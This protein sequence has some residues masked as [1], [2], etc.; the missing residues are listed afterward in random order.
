MSKSTSEIR[1]TFLDF[2]HSKGHQIVASS[3]L[4]PD[5]NSTLLFTNAG[6][7]QFQNVFLGLEKRPYLRAATAQR[8][9]RAGGKHNDL[10]NVGYSEYHHTFF[11]MLGNFSFG[12]Y[13]K[14]EAI[15]FAWELLTSKNW[16]N[17]S[18]DNL[19]VT[20]YS[21]DHESYHIWTNNIGIQPD[22]IIRI[23]DNKGGA[24]A[25]DNFWQMGS[26]GPC[27]P[28][29]EIFYDHGDHLL[30]GLP[31]TLEDNGDR[32]IEIWNLVFIQFNR[33]SDGSMVPLPFISIDTG[34]GLERISAIIQKVN[35]NYEI[36][37]FQKLINA[38]AKST[39]TTDLHN[40]SL[41][42]IAD[43]IRS[44]TFLLSDGVRPSNEGR[45]YV[46]RRIIRRAI[47]HGKILGIKKCFLYKLVSQL[48]DDSGSIA[49]QLR[50]QQIMVEDILRTE[51]E[52]F[53]R[54]LE[55]GIKL[56]DEVLVKL[57]GDTLDGKIAFSLHDTY[58]FPI[59]L[60]ADICRERKIK[61][62]YTS[63]NSA[64]ES[65]RKRARKFNKFST[66]TNSLFRIKQS[67]YF[68]GYDNTEQ[69]GY[70]KALFRNHQLV[71]MINQGEHAVIVL[72]KTPFFSES[73]GQVSDQGQLYNNSSLFQVQDTKKYHLA[74]G[75]AGQLIYGN[76]KLG[77]Q[78]IAK[79]DQ[80]RRNRICLN[81][82]ATHLLHASLRKVLGD[83]IRQKGSFINDHYLRFD[84]SH[85]EAI[86]PIQ[87]R[88]IEEMVNQQIRRNMLIQTDI[89]QLEVAREKGAVALFSEKYDQQVRV[90]TIGDFSTEVCGGIHARRTG[91][92]GVFC[93]IRE[94]GISAGV[95]RIEA[96]TGQCALDRLNQQSDLLNK[97]TQIIQVDK[98]SLVNKVQALK[99][100]FHKLEKEIYLLK[101]KQAQKYTASLISSDVKIINGVQ[102]LVN[103][104]NNINRKQLHII[105][106]ELKNKLGSAVIVLATVIDNK[107]FLIAGVTKDLTNR[108]KADELINHLAQKVCGK[109]GGCSEMAQAGGTDVDALPSALNS[110]IDMLSIVL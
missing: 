56:L 61:L 95:R 80:E 74:S 5:K 71:D 62:D 6:M 72:D 55:R 77:E 90:L 51:E 3:S 2:F 49:Y 92:I 1:Q 100:N 85:K 64:M 7:N 39:D 67:T 60:T 69:Q 22:R 12:D 57:T 36:D 94:S 82:S 20:V 50:S 63:F 38:I 17:L 53:E 37:I 66:D 70:V 48:I 40:K 87:I 86:N 91:D 16:F 24:Y 84:F 98:N 102:V 58:G 93:I 59:D 101:R 31:G 78:V 15:L 23:G 26:T 11:E 33:Q 19:L 44:C 110:I 73:G 45:G 21:S 41:R 10:D 108:V 42:V 83:N 43:H 79:V 107:I 27:G 75:H 65:Q 104:I 89:M 103:Q 18:K 14:Y 105:A 29:S 13:F 30:G 46:L 96:I 52:S 109:G 106:D 32:Y 88:L 76:I 35:S 28:C 9:V 97:I 99:D 54:S 4:V 25:S 81:H 34:M 47:R 8:C 68:T